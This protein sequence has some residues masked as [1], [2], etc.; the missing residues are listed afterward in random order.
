MRSLFLLLAATLLLSG[1]STKPSAA[2]YSGDGPN[3]HY[4]KTERAGGAV[5]R[6]TYH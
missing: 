4:V 6:T 3:I 1:C 2:V 5:E